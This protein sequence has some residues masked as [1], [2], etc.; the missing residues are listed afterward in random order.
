[1][2]ITALRLGLLDHGYIP[3]PITNP[4]RRAKIR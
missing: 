2:N 3:L 1:M 4:M